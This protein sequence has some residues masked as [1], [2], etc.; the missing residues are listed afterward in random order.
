MIIFGFCSD[1]ALD[2]RSSSDSRLP[3]GIAGGTPRGQGGSSLP[4]SLV[5]HV[6]MELVELDQKIPPDSEKIGSENS[7]WVN[8]PWLSTTKSSGAGRAEA[9]GVADRHWVSAQ[10]KH[11]RARMFK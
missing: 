9:R 5:G 8:H 4:T 3:N 10:V 1:L 7:V 6:P 2:L 11:D